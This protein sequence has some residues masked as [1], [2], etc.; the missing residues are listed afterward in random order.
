MLEDGEKGDL[1]RRVLHPVVHGVEHVEVGGEVHIVGCALARLVT[2]LLLIE[3]VELDLEVRVL[4]LSLYVP[5]D[6]QQFQS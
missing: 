1:L 6:L 3:H 5:E 4:G 2:L